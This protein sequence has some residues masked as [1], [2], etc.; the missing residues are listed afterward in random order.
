[1][2]HL[3]KSRLLTALNHLM[4]LFEL[5]HLELVITSQSKP[6]ALLSVLGELNGEE[7]KH[8]KMQQS[9]DGYMG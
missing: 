6:A 3:V 9:C 4:K 7:I 2:L 1:M 8:R 5:S